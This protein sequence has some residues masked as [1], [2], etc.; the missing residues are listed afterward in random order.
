MLHH[1]R[2]HGNAANHG[3]RKPSSAASFRQWTEEKAASM[4]VALVALTNVGL[5][6]GHGDWG[7]FRAVYHR[8]TVVRTD[9]G[10]TRLTVVGPN[11]GY[12]KCICNL[13]ITD[14][15]LC[16]YVYSRA[17]TAFCISLFQW[18]AWEFARTPHCR[19]LKFL[20]FIV[21]LEIS[22]QHVKPVNCNG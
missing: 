12:S 15:T 5:N 16:T 2:N 20:R 1:T 19:I 13:C 6:R 7:R 9:R 21:S 4:E 10:S 8:Q 14:H 18:C 3:S 22:T 11:C 17:Q